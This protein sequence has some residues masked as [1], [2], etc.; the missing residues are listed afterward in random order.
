MNVPIPKLSE[1]MTMGDSLR[2]RNNEQW[3]K[4]LENG[5]YCGCAIGGA[6]LAAGRTGMFDHVGLWPWLDSRPDLPNRDLFMGY[7]TACYETIIS[8]L[9]NAVC[10][11]EMEFDD[12]VAY[13]R[14]SEP[15]CGCHRFYCSC[16]RETAP[17]T[18]E[19]EV[20]CV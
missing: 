12:L 10:R 15:Q 20:V 3:L 14:Y 13:V 18:V 4:K 7:L 6:T 19:E 11:G 5:T 8:H 17:A 1:A 9:F 16:V 2:T